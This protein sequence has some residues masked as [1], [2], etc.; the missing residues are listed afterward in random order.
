MVDGGLMA[1]RNL[2]TDDTEGVVFIVFT[3]RGVICSSQA[4][5]FE[6][7][8]SGMTRRAWILE[9]QR[10]AEKPYAYLYQKLAGELGSI[11]SW[12]LQAKYADVKRVLV[13]GNKT[14]S[15]AQHNVEADM[16]VVR[17]FVD[18]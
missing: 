7:A 11:I 10:P 8:G 3:G 14:F 9:I 18:N 13:S 5:Q 16:D 4:P 15:D 6:N 17:Q 2:F 1:Q 12:A